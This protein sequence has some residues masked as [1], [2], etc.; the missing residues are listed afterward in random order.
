[1]LA[2]V[3]T[4]RFD[5]LL[6]AFDD[7]PLLDFL[8]DKA[9]HRIQDHFFTKDDLP[10]LA[11]V[12]AYAEGPIIPRPESAGHP[13]QSKSPEWRMLL[14]DNDVPLFNAL[15]SWRAERAKREGVPAY[16]ICTNSQLAR[17]AS[18]RPRSLAGLGA[19]NGVGKAKLKNYGHDLLA[20]LASH[21]DAQ[22]VPAAESANVAPTARADAAEDPPAASVD[23]K[24]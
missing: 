7:S 18:T 22:A 23:G 19:I 3:I 9:V 13:T 12:I 16:V 1:M 17:M 10:Y 8:K 20:L 2:R 11:V 15:R 4:L 6:G 21:P 24:A 14:S 5:P